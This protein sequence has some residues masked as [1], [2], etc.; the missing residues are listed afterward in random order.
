M[1]ITIIKLNTFIVYNI[2]RYCTQLY[3]TNLIMIESMISG[4]LPN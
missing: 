3:A 4:Y 1:E 2:V